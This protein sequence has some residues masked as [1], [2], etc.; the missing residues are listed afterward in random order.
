MTTS[1]I[2]RKPVVIP[3][4]V[5]IK[6]QDQ[7]ILAKGPKGQ[8]SLALHPFVKVVLEDKNI[9]VHPNAECGRVTSA[10]TKLY[11][12]ITGTMR[13][14]ID[15]AIYGVTHGFEKKLALV[16]VGYRAQVKGKILSLSLGF[17]HPT[18]FHVPEGIT[19][20][21]PTQTDIVIKGIDKKLVGQVAAKIRE[22]RC[23]EPYKGKGVR[24]ANETIE[25]KETKKK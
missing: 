10:N 12:S 25:L 5:D 4:G 20:E 18:D 8:I 23:P 9:K 21:T 3:S 16:G 7:K 2:G 17:S 15:N 19:I 24:Y 22:I 6:I 1:R 11:R 14:N 13:A